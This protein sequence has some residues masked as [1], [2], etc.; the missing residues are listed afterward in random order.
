MTGCMHTH[1]GTCLHAAVIN[2]HG[3]E[4]D[5][6]VKLRNFLTLS[7]EQAICKL[8]KQVLWT[9]HVNSSIQCITWAHMML[10]L[11]MAVTLVLL[12]LVA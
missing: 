10:A 7:Q 9:S 8:P 12:C 3:V 2:D 6:G 4:F 5:V 1:N 11:W